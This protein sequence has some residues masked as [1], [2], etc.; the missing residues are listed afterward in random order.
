[1][2]LTDDPT[3]AMSDDSGKTPEPAEDAPGSVLDP[4][5][6]DSIRQQVVLRDTKALPGAA[7]CDCLH[8]APA[9]TTE[10]AEAQEMLGG[11]L[12]LPHP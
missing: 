10:R 4:R 11:P 8:W 12:P 9:E 7:A 2:P 5:R 1:M 3:D 6:C